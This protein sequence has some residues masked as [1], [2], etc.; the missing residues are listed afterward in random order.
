MA[1]RFTLPILDRKPHFDERSRSFG[2]APYV[3]DTRLK[4]T[5]WELPKT[6]PLDQG[7]EGA[8]VGFG[9][10]TELAVGPV[11]QMVSNATA[12]SYYRGAVIEDHKMGNNFE[13]EGASVLAGAKYGKRV[14][15]LRSYKWAF[16][17]DQV[18]AALCTYGPVILGINWYDSMYETDTVGRVLVNGQLVG[19][20]CICATG[21]IPADDAEKMGLGKYDVIEWM[22]TW[23]KVYGIGGVGY[24]RRIDLDTLLKQDGEAV[25][26]TD[27]MRGA[28]RR[29]RRGSWMQ[30][31]LDSDVIK[32]VTSPFRND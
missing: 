28:N 22:N 11:I 18:V 25:I 30:Q 20:H 12:E 13:G 16:G 24:I 17:I 19:G 2:I 15:V 7:A 14:A 26:P 31:R 5:L 27:V 8:C 21:Y 3:A 6:L 29:L 4:K 32:R 10:S 1:A 9:W 23:G